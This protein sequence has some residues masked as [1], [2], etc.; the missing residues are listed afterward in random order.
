M[1]K[2]ERDCPIMLK[3]QQ[4]ENE[5][6]ISHTSNIPKKIYTKIEYIFAIEYLGRELL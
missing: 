1:K 3:K 5:I 2:R 4:L 6:K